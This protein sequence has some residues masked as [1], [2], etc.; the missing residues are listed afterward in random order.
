MRYAEL[1]AQYRDLLSLVGGFRPQA[2]VDG[3]GGKRVAV[4]ICVSVDRALQRQKQAERIAA[5]GYGDEQA[6]GTVEGEEKVLDR[7]FR[8][9]FGQ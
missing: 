4:R 5:T 9:A 2:V 8:R 3:C 7:G 1:S 6:H